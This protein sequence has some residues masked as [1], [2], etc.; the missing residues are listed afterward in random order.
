MCTSVSDKL[1]SII[2]SDDG[3]RN[4]ITFCTNGKQGQKVGTTDKPRKNKIYDSGKEE[5]FKTKLNRI[6][7]NKN[8]KLERPENFKSLGVK[9]NEDNNHKTHLQ[10]RIKNANKTYLMLQ[11]FF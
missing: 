10:E 7:E 11:N 3:G 8:Y 2:C 5:Q 9:L 4:K 6:F 1:A